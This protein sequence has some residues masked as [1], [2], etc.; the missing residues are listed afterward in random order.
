M[1]YFIKAKILTNEKL[2]WRVG[3]WNSVL[4]LESI[5]ELL[6]KHAVQMPPSLIIFWD[7]E[8]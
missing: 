7:W 5:T 4:E 1:K 3:A 8:G 2:P 6:N